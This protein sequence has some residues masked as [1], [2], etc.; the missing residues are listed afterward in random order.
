MLLLSV[1]PAMAISL[2]GLIPLL[3]AMI[4]LCIVIYA[5]SIVLGM[6]SLP[7]PVKQLIWLIVAVVVSIFLLN[8]LGP[9]H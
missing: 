4:I 3:V 9:V 8:L 7:P 1:L 5:V 6:L 2:E